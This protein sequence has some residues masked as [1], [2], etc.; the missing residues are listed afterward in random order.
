[1]MSEYSAVIKGSLKLKADSK[2]KK[3]SK[4]HRRKAKVEKE[5]EVIAET[6]DSTEPASTNK[7]NAFKLTKTKS[8]LEFDRRKEKRLLETILTKAEKSHKQRIIDLN[9]RLNEMSE[10]F[11][12]PKVSWTK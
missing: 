4:R 2:I 8:E 10:H 12:I 7:D 5:P 3:K 9:R 1:M 11:D 6:A